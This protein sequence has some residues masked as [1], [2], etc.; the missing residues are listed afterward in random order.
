MSTQVIDRV[1]E[2]SRQKGSALA[3]MLILANHANR[4]SVCWPKV[5]L[6]ATE[7]RLTPRQTKEL[8]GQLEVAGEIRVRRNTTGRQ[9][10]NDYLVTA[11]VPG[12]EWPETGEAGFTRRAGGVNPGSPRGE[13]EFTPRVNPGSPRRVKRS[14]KQGE[15]GEAGF[16]PGVNPGSRGGEAQRTPS[17][18]GGTVIEPSFDSPPLSPPEEVEVPADL[19]GFHSELR[20]QPGYRPTSSLFSKILERYLALDLVEEAMG[21]VAWLDT[22]NEKFKGRTPR[23][24]GRLCSNLFI[25]RWLG[26]SKE[27]RQNGNDGA[28]RLGGHKPGATGSDGAGD[29]EPQLRER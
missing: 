23:E 21:M 13:A 4:Q 8:L 29:N 20:G 6:L 22:P 12:I 10:G 7:I 25:L 14:A 28:G 19:E 9:A 18:G 3:L 5:G 2:H 26:R 15:T 1:L 24:A 17:K 27:S 11:G 16:T